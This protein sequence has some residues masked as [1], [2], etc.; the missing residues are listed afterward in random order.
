MAND[1]WAFG[2]SQLLT[3]IGFC[4]TI[5]IA[6]GGFKTFGRWKREKVEEL[7]MNIAL[8]ALSIAYETQFV[9]DG[10]R[11]PGSFGYEYADM[12]RGENESPEQYEARKTGYPTLKRVNDNKDFFQQVFKLQPRF[13]AVF[14]PQTEVIF[15]ELNQARVNVIVSAQAISR[16]DH[17]PFTEAKA[18]RRTRHEADIWSGAADAYSDEELPDGDRVQKRLDEFKNGISKLCRPVVDHEFRDTK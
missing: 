17:S 1:P 2:W 15:K 4:I 9:F 12:K 5:G 6:I 14:G 11:N 8:E 18:K 7:R 3:I 16:D 10:I 13:M